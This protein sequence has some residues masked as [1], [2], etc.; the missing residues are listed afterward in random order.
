MNKS[1]TK[2]QITI[3]IDVRVIT[4]FKKLA[5]ESGLPYQVL[6]N[7]YLVDCMNKSVRPKVQW[8]APD[9]SKD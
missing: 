4:Y 1:K 6:I 2:Q 8:E 7:L 5:H 9:N 3:N